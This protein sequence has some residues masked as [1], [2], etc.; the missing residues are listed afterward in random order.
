MERRIPT[1]TPPS[2]RLAA[3]LEKSIARGEWKIGDVLPSIHELAA[4]MNVGVKTARKALDIL[5]AEG[6]TKPRRGIGS[7]VV[8]RGVAAR[9]KGRV[10][11]YVRETG[12][13]YYSAEFLATIGRRLKL[14]GYSISTVSAVTR[15]ESPAICQFQEALKE[16]WSL[17]LL[18]G[19]AVE[20]RRLAAASGWPFVLVGDGAPLPRFSAPTCIGRFE[21]RCGK[22]VPVFIRECVRRRVSRIVQFKYVEGAFD[23]TEMLAHAG[24]AVE[25]VTVPRKSSPEEVSR[26]ALAD[27]RKL[28]AKKRLPD[29]FLFTD[30]CVAQG[31]LTALAVAGVRIPEDV[32]VVTHANKGLGPVWEKPLSRLEMDA[33]AHAAAVSRA[34]ADYLK[35][36]VHPPELDL[37]S[38]YKPGATF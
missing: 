23:V 27:M 36:G 4:L 34:V 26:A 6:W 2:M 33:A 5:E 28:A 25:T 12:Y 10:L 29:L 14:H 38:V 30:D 15:T 31:A 18:C 35:T 22:A 17:V 20:A 9:E 16:R 7:V 3:T 13:S 32:K 8:D 24:V 19:G 1:K 11:V 21:I 37:G